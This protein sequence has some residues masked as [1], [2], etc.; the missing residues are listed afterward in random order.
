M[1]GRLSHSQIYTNDLVYR[2]KSR[3]KKANKIFK[4]IKS[5]YGDNYKNAK[6]LD[7]GCA[8]GLI[9]YYLSK[10]FKEVV[11]ADVDEIAIKRAKRNRKKK[12]SFRLLN[13]D[14]SFPFKNNSFDIIVANQIYEHADDPDLLMNEIFRVLKTNGVV[15]MGAGNKF[16]IRDAHY[17]NLPFVSWIPIRLA[18]FYVR[19][20][21]SGEYYEPRLRS[22]WGI[23]DLIKKFQAE[24]YTLK[25]IK[26][27]VKYSMTDVVHKGSMMTKLPIFILKLMYPIIP[28]YLLILRKK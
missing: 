28:N 19:T 10:H 5:A 11:G 17:P 12:L 14:G 6:L 27:P 9:S 24:D 21:K 4:I 26:S 8:E 23:K 7:V 1:T 20:T 2:D 25:A 15:F 18:D 22:V 3:L 16:V 13:S